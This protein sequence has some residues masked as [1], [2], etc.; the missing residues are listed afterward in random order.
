MCGLADGTAS[1]HLTVKTVADPHFFWLDGILVAH[2]HFAQGHFGSHHGIPYVID[3]DQCSRVSQ[4]FEFLIDRQGE[5]ASLLCHPVAE[6]GV[7]LFSEVDPRPMSVFD[8]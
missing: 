5:I 8:E 7:N 4:G 2:Q 3:R 6:W 1:A